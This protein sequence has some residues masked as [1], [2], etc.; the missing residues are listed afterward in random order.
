MTHISSALPQPGSSYVSYNL[1]TLKNSISG[2]P[3]T[4]AVCGQMWT[5]RGK[6]V[7]QA[8]PASGGRSRQSFNKCPICSGKCHMCT[9]GNLGCSPQH[10]FSLTSAAAPKTETQ[11]LQCSGS[12]RFTRSFIYHQQAYTILMQ[13]SDCLLFVFL[14]CPIHIAD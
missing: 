13:D 3:C 5:E 7:W 10:S 1:L 6:D 2:H 9:S 12:T 4:W 11:D 8:T 14:Y